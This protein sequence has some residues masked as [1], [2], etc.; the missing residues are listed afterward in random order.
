[1]ADTL[2]DVNA[3]KELTPYIVKTERTPSL[4]QVVNNGLNGVVHIQN[5]GVVNF[6]IDVQFVLHKSNDESVYTAYQ[7][8]HLLQVR[9][10]DRE[11]FGYITAVAL[12]EDYADGYHAGRLVLQ[13]EVTQ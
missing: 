3:G 8:G 7:N 12:E 11:Y 1:M 2:Y 5:I 13:Q 4:N 9:D 6:E 10:D